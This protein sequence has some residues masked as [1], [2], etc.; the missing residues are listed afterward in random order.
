LIS[1]TAGS[2]NTAVGVQSLALLTTADYNTAI[3][4]EAGY[5]NQ[6]HHYNT[7]VGSK[8]GYNNTY[9]RN[10]FIGYQCG[11][12]NVDGWRNTYIGSDAGYGN[13]SGHR[14]TMVGLNSGYNSTGNDNVFV[15]YRAGYDETG[16]NKLH[17][18][19]YNSNATPLIWGDFAAH[20][21]GI[22]RVAAANAF[23]VN[24]N[25]SKTTA[26][27]WLANSDRRI[28]TDIINIDGAVE[29]IMQLRPVKFRYTDEW[30]ERNPG[31]EDRYY[32]NFIAQ[33]FRDVFPESVKGS[34][35][36]LA[37][38]PEEILQID[39]YNAQ[40]V[41]IKAIQEQQ[42]EIERLKQENKLL[43]Q[44]LAALDNL[45]AEVENLKQYI[46]QTAQNN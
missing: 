12:G 34:G 16:D 14:N 46:Y 3:G 7:F 23:E 18:A 45:K 13:Q 19:N 6:D 24:G 35:E 20:R 21:V 32:Y 10:T 42:Q 27:D 26:G 11:Y 41:A 30:M 38:D 5:S 25:A 4:S 29:T 9:D 33:E 37:S 17:I 8:A 43:K 39:T 22:Y 1:T 31:I 44:K 28:K 15:G 36:Y 40:V 2:S